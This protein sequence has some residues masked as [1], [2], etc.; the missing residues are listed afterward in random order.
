MHAK[1]TS[2]MQQERHCSTL[3]TT[4]KALYEEKILSEGIEALKCSKLTKESI[5]KVLTRFRFCVR[6]AIWRFTSSGAVR[7]VTLKVS[8]TR[9]RSNDSNEV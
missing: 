8:R 7:M 5:Y 3:H 1:A 6:E 2:T 4:I 9:V